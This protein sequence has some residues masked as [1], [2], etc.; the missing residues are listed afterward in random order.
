MGQSQDQPLPDNML[1]LLILITCTAAAP[2]WFPHH[3]VAHLSPY[4]FMPYALQHVAR[5]ETPA[6]G[7][8]LTT[9]TTGTLDD[10]AICGA[11]GDT[12][13]TATGNA[14]FDQFTTDAA[15]YSVYLVGSGVEV[16]KEYKIYVLATCTTAV[17]DAAK[18]ATVTSPFFMINGFRLSGISTTFIAEGTVDGKTQVSG[19][20]IA[21]YNDDDTLI[22]CTNAAM[23]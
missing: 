19:K 1:L 7:R 23:T 11:A 13:C 16:S 3:P 10:T 12:A 17:S 18:L 9:S 6:E 14:M 5:V 4:G 15:K 20:F 22:G 8:F 21:V 2:Q